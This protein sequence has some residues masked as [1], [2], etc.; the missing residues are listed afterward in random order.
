MRNED[1]NAI[2]KCRP[3]PASAHGFFAA[4]FHCYRRAVRG[5]QRLRQTMLAQLEGT[6]SELQQAATRALQEAEALAWQ[7]PV[8]HLVFPTLAEEKITQA[9]QWAFH[10]QRIQRQSRRLWPLARAV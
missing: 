4:C 10:Q 1:Y 3:V 6:S 7:T 8:P 5:I 2:T 9:R